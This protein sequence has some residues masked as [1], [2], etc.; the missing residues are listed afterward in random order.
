MKMRIVFVAACVCGVAFGGMS[1][2]GAWSLSYRLQ[3][4]G[5][6]WKTVSATVPGDALI[7]LERA[8]VISDPM[9]GT[10]AWGLF[11]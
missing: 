9:V 3:Q 6:E 10:N 7:D 2:D 11:R 4:E 8:G 1:L 5:G